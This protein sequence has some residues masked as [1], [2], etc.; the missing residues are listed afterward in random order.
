MHHCWLGFIKLEV[1]NWIPVGACK[2][3]IQASALPLVQ[4]V[5]GEREGPQGAKLMGDVGWPFKLSVAACGP[6]L[7]CVRGDWTPVVIHD[8]CLLQEGSIWGEVFGGRQ[9][10]V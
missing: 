3:L 2:V 8:A 5:C 10:S 7:L 4:T 6:R 1:V 9:R